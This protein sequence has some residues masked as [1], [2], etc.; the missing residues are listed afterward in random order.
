MLL[1]SINVSVLVPAFNEERTICEVIER[2]S[3]G[4]SKAGKTGEIIIVNDGSSDSTQKKVI[5]KA[6][7]VPIVKLVNHSRNLG[8]PQAL[9]TGLETAK[10]DLIII[11]PADLESNPEEDIPR[12]LEKMIDVDMVSGWRQGR[13]GSKIVASTLY[14][15]LYRYLFKI[16]VHDANWIKCFRRSIIDHIVWTQDWNRYLV[17]FAAQAGG[18]IAEVKVTYYKRDYGQSKFGMTRLPGGF[19]R[20]LRMY[21]D[22]RKSNRDPVPKISP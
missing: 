3:R 14:N 10:G 12:L 8:L 18:K 4:L 2:S 20:F 21:R 22:I 19:V 11:L 1:V 9:R 13:T 6:I 5:E 7:D 16:D 17:L 15:L